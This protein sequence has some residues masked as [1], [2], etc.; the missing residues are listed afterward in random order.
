MSN[1]VC[2]SH[3]IANIKTRD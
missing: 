3:T 2:V 1:S